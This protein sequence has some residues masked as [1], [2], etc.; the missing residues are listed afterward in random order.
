MNNGVQ[1]LEVFAFECD[2]LSAG[3]SDVRV[4]L[5]GIIRKSD[6]EQGQLRVSCCLHKVKARGGARDFSAGGRSGEEQTTHI[7]RLPQLVDRGRTGLRS[8]V[9]QDAHVRLQDRSE[10][11]E[12]PSVRVDLLCA[13][14]GNQEETPRQTR[15]TICD[16]V[17]CARP[18]PR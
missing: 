12:E 16:S 2:D 18:A 1:V 15:R 17:S 6:I 8:H 4:Q 9:E 11:V 10:S 5:T 13:A 3:A 7:E 14:Q